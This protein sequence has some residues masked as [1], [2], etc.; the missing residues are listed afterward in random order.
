MELGLK[1]S[2][3]IQDVSVAKGMLKTIPNIHPKNRLLCMCYFMKEL[4]I[5]SLFNFPFVVR[6]EWL[7]ATSLHEAAE[8]RPHTI[9]MY[10]T[11]LEQLV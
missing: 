7:F 3:P 9:L 10:T 4:L 5:C 1:L 8:S 6:M 11:V 2:V